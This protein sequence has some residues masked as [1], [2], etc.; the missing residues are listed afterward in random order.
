MVFK[1][2]KFVPM[3][4]DLENDFVANKLGKHKEVKIF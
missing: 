2:K 4:S 3:L 1:R